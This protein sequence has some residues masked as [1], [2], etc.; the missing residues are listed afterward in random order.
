MTDAGFNP[1]M[2]AG[3]AVA[4][5]AGTP[6]G[7]KR[8]G[9]AAA[10]A[11]DAKRVLGMMTGDVKPYMRNL[12]V[13]AKAL[14][15][16]SSEFKSKIAEI[17]VFQAQMHRAEFLNQFLPEGSKIATRQ[18]MDALPH[19]A[20]GSWWGH[21]DEA[22]GQK[23]VE[24]G[25]DRTRSRN[26]GIRFVED[27]WK[28][29]GV[30]D[31]DF[32]VLL[33]S[34]DEVNKVAKTAERA[35]WSKLGDRGPTFD[36]GELQRDVLEL[37]RP[38]KHGFDKDAFPRVLNEWL[39]TKLFPG[40][41]GGA[42]TRFSMQ[43]YQSARSIL[44]GVMREAEFMPTA[45]N[46]RA[47]SFAYPILKKMEKQLDDWLE[48]DVSNFGIE[49]A[50]ARSLTRKNKIL[51]DPKMPVVRAIE[52]G[53]SPDQLFAGVR[54][55]RG[56]RG[57][58]TT[59]AQEAQRLVDTVGS[60]NADNLAGLAV[61]DLFKNNAGEF[62]SGKTRQA[63]KI[64]KNQEAAY[65]I[66]L[67]DRYDLATRY[68]ET[69]SMLRT[70][71]LGTPGDVHKTGS[72]IMP[73]D[74]IARTAADTNSPIMGLSRVASLIRKAVPEGLSKSELMQARILLAAMEDPKFARILTEMPT[75]KNI[76]AWKLG[77]Q[78]LLRQASRGASYQAARA[79]A[80]SEATK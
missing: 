73:L 39:D 64:L 61:R 42:D 11:V 74:V 32:N 15:S 20:G 38:L 68:L 55:A 56:Y 70:G 80:T 58:R 79:A 36:L 66:L 44:S 63:L 21:A 54:S 48:T 49:Y 72:K 53:G 29:L 22:I 26:V 5:G 77:W 30:E 27:G 2:A 47:A 71:G 41:V 67:G 52:K 45:A 19:G 10:K 57:T 28:G 16:G 18:A 51:Y 31:T 65:R 35:A 60:E 7:A 8:L 24:Y 62:D 78:Q 33:D 40:E 4:F 9:A 34:Y 37:K 1:L 6:T 75:E 25:L 23:N 3:P 46:K 17:D 43:D 76:V 69:T 59:P 50:N 13:N 14:A 12:G